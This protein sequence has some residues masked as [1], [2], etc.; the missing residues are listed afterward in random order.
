MPRS[1]RGDLVAA[2]ASPASAE[3]GFTLVETLVSLALCALVALL[4]L[5]TLQA[6]AVINDSARRL[7]AQEEADLVRAHLRRAFSERAV[8]RA[9]GRHAPFLG[10][11]DRLVMTIQ[12]DREA[13]RGAETRLDLGVAPTSAGLDLVETNGPAALPGPPELLLKGIRALRVRYFGVQGQESVP[14]WAPAWTRKDRPPSLVEVTVD[15]PPADGRLWPPL[16]LAIGS[17]V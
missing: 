14:R 2:D 16:I 7:G 11:P 5:Q 9:S 4:T 17:G 6:T 1:S 8:R 3:A 13:G 10:Q 12:A 15:F